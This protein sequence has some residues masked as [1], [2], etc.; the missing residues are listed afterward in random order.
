MEP[1]LVAVL[2]LM[3]FSSGFWLGEMRGMR[4]GRLWWE[5]VVHEQKKVIEEYKTTC[6][7]YAHVFINLQQEYEATLKVI[8]KGAKNES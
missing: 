2:C 1:L 3:I 7:A 6:N 5:D 8:S 4:K